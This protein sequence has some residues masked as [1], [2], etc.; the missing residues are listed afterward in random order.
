MTPTRQSCSG[1]AP[2]EDGAP[3]PLIDT[4][5]HL[6]ML[7]D[8][9]AAIAT[10]LQRAAAA[11][12]AT[13]ITIGIDEASSQAAVDIARH[14][15]NVW[16]T[17]GVHPHDAAGVSEET[18]RRLTALARDP[19]VVAWGEIG[20]DLAKRYSPPDAQEEVFRRQ[21]RLAADLDLP[22]VIH[23]REAHDQVL[24]ILDE[25]GVPARG[26]V[27]HCFSGDVALAR[28][29]LDRGLLLSIP[30]VVT[31][32]N[33]EQLREVVRF[34]PLDRLLLETDAPFLAPVPFRGKRNEPALLVHTARM[35]AATA[36]VPLAEVARQTTATARRFFRLSDEPQGESCET[37]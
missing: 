24:A 31:F 15:A 2:Q 32:K 13:V 26:G 7:G 19:R 4:H 33:G 20:M 18:W 1:C 14:Y 28:R 3:P 22:V 17:V 12:V 35:V 10:V 11:G 25:E 6:D 9:R 8:Q 34:A 30:G 36:G 16:A 21:L 5:C 29:V 37:C 27:M 23:D